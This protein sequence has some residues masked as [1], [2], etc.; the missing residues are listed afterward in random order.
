MKRDLGF[1]IQFSAKRM[2]N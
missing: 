2:V 1:Y